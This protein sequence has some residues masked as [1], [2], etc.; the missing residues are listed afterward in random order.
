VNDTAGRA[1]VGEPRWICLRC[2]W[3]GASGRAECPRCGELLYRETVAAE[4]EP[5][6][7][8]PSALPSG[9]P[10]PAETAERAADAPAA[11]PSRSPEPMTPRIEGEEEPPPSTR[12]GAWS[13]PV[14]FGAA[15]AAVA[16][17]AGLVWAQH[18]SGPPTSEAVA[19][20]LQGALV[21]ATGGEDGRTGRLWT[22]DLG[23]GR[24]VRG[25]RTV[26]PD[27]IVSSGP[28]GHWV[29][30][31]AGGAS[32]VFHGLGEDV[33]PQ[34]V[35]EGRLA[36]WAPGGN[37]A[38]VVTQEPAPPGGDCPMLRISFVDSGTRGQ[39]DLYEEP[40]CSTVNGLAIDGLTRPFVSLTGGKETA[41]VYEL[42]YKRLHLLVRGSTLLSVSPVGDML[43][44]ARFA[45]PRGSGDTPSLQTLLVW[46]G[47]GG[48][49]VIGD[50][51]RDLAAERF[52][53]WSEDGHLAALL[54]TMGL[55]RSVWLVETGPGAR[56]RRPVQVAPALPPHLESVGVAFAGS[57]VLTAAAGRL[58]VSGG[59]GYAEVNLPPGA[60]SPSGP[61]LWL[62]R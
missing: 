13:R 12:R 62:D 22:V 61:L 11:P 29:G 15:A 54:G 34:L 6:S 30:V 60:P 2:D 25:P 17:V 46:Q 39:S 41:G 56:R 33:M 4:P 19:R 44:A 58:Y 57:T 20:A 45:W 37:A 53:G 36:A 31:L 47:V 14:R 24:A 51:T 8:R 52:L 59:R 50:A 10:L 48:P 23:E 5:V 35:A 18:G 43:V 16:L 42:G 38:F 40:S 9:A 26:L 3:E 21:Y 28:A 55:V 1:G 32:Y 27:Q 7:V 49:T